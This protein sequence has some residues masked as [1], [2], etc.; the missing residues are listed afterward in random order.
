MR[1]DDKLFSVL[2]D[3]FQ[4]QPVRRA[5]LF[6]SVARGKA[7]RGSDVDILVWFDESV[8]LLQHAR[9][10]L[11]LST[12]LKRKVDLISEGGLSPLLRPFIEE[13]A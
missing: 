8:S 1:P 4:H 2:R 7:R 13:E 3:Y 5:S 10:Q 6:G 11:A 12:L 9:M